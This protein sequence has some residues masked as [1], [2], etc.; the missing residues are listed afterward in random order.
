M[1]ANSNT[2]FK[3]ITNSQYNMNIPFQK[4]IEKKN[5]NAIE[6]LNNF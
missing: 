2:I 5:I 3:E 6:R 1:S 4:Y